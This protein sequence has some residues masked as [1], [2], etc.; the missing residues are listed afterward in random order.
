MSVYTLCCQVGPEWGG[1]RH[2]GPNGTTKDMQ[3]APLRLGEPQRGSPFSLPAPETLTA[4]AAAAAGPC[5]T[6]WRAHRSDTRT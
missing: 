2:K 1:H 6:G 4:Q 5:V 3:E